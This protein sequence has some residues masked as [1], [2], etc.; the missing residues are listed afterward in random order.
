MTA[1]AANGVAGICPRSNHWMERLA[2]SF[3]W[4]VEAAT[5][6]PLR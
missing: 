4:T 2:A 6:H 3:G 1:I 5:V